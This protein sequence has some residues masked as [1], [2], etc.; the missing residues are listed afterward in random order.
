MIYKFYNILI[1]FVKYMENPIWENYWT[2]LEQFCP[3]YLIFKF[4]FPFLRT[5]RQQI[6]IYY[7]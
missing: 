3:G 6:I 1:K 2:L 5:Y 4:E 7:L